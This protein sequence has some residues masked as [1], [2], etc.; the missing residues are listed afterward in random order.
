VTALVIAPAGVLMGMFFPSG[1]RSVGELAPGF[2]PWAWG[3]NGC[4]SVYGSVVAILTAMVYGFHVTLAVGAAVY[5]CGF[6]AAR[7]FSREQTAG[8]HS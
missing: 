8:P 1:L 4:M 6:V 5:A 3:I 2:I 7:G